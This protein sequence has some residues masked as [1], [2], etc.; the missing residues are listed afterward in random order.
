MNEHIKTLL[1]AYPLDKQ[2]SSRVMF[3][4]L[5]RAR[6]PVKI[7][8]CRNKVLFSGADILTFLISGTP[9]FRLGT[10][11]V[12]FENLAD[13]A[14][15]PSVPSFDRTG[16]VGYYN[17]LGS[18]PDKDFIR[19]PITV[20]PA[21]SSSDESVYENNLATFFAVTEGLAGFHGKSFGPSANSAVYGAALVA[22]P[23]VDDQSQDRVYARTYT[24]IGKLLKQ[25]G[26]EIGVTW[27]TRFN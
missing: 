2:C 16:G 21:L 27:Q 19:V 1:D 5:D 26:F 24:G 7:V 14:D 3:M 9:G 22:S 6:R 4:L 12:E 8:E 18:S 23:E 25:S 10:M 13:P 11:Y 20:S 17:G 15:A